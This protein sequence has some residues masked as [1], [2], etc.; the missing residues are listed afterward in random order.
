[1]ECLFLYVNPIFFNRLESPDSHTFSESS[2]ISS[3]R[4]MSGFSFMV[5]LIF[6]SVC[7]VIFLL[8][9]LY[10]LGLYDPVVRHSFHIFPIELRLVFFTHFIM[11]FSLSPRFFASII[12]SLFSFETGLIK[13]VNYLQLTLQASTDFNTD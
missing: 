4:V 7:G 13:P 12:S 10:G 3:C 1:M 2:S 6:S 5:C 8:L 9:P 11:F